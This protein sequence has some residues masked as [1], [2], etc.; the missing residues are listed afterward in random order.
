[1]SDLTTQV[2]ALA[3]RLAQEINA[4]RAELY[5]NGAQIDGGGATL[6]ANNIVLDGGSA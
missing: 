5:S 3:S 2:D 1:M 6:S 4:V